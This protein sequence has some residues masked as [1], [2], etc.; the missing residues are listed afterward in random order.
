M[1][2]GFID[3][4]NQVLVSDGL[5]VCRRLLAPGKEILDAHLEC[6]IVSIVHCEERGEE[7]IE[8][9]RVWVAARRLSEVLR[10]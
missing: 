4:C 7:L 2:R 3:V 5:H 1:I 9:D 6:P 10:W 8:D